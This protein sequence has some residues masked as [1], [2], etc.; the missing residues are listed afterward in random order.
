MHS[1]H[2]CDVILVGVA[3]GQ[4]A[5]RR[6][7]PVG[8][9]KRR[10]GAEGRAVGGAMWPK[11]TEKKTTSWRSEPTVPQ[12][13]VADSSGAPSLA[14]GMINVCMLL[15]VNFYA[16][17]VMDVVSWRYFR[18]SFLCLISSAMDIVGIFMLRVQK[19]PCFMS[20]VFSSRRCYSWMYLCFMYF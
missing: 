7:A 17:C 3:L 14:A 19:F 12:R 2:V 20:H 4:A 18:P 5:A 13:A 11:K 15:H 8:S 9:T 16:S 6:G 10:C 1:I